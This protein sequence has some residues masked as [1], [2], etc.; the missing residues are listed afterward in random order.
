MATSQQANSDADGRPSSI[1]S[2]SV[3]GE[4]QLKGPMWISRAQE[5]TGQHPQLL[6]YD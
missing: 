4:D 6:P 2:E 5:T 3:A 1:H